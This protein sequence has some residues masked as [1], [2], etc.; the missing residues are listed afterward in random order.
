[1]PAYPAIP[2]FAP[3][4]PTVQLTEGA[5]QTFKL[6]A[7]V[8]LDAS[9]FVTECGADPA[10]ISGFAGHP[11]TKGIPITVDLVH[12]AWEGQKFWMSA[13]PAGG[14]LVYGDTNKTYGITKDANGI[15]QLD[16]SKTAAAARL[17]I[18]YV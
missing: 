6:G 7:A 8:V 10:L 17:Y 14:A 3:E 16:R 5:A 9:Q 13:L 4:S 12:K 18:H 1:M 11:A 2:A 15:W